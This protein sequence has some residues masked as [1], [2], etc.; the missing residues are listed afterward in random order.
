[1]F[2]LPQ[3]SQASPGIIHLDESEDI[4]ERLLRM[5]FGLPLI[6]I[7]SFD[8]VDALLG[9]IEKYDMP[10]PLSIIRL[11]VMTPPLV[12]EPFRLYSVSCRFGW[13]EERKHAS[14]QTLTVNLH[15]R[16]IRPQLES[17]STQA[18]LNLYD[19]HFSRREG[20]LTS[21]IALMLSNLPM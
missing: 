16:E 9:A 10:G 4:I 7:E 6:P 20:Y 3:K 17:L 15:S 19:L 18:L 8:V 12:N 13:D 1:M 2:T 14:Q 5:I 11:I 21:I